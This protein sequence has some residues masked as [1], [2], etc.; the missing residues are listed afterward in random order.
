M[1]KLIENRQSPLSTDLEGWRVVIAQGRLA[2]LRFEP[3]IAAL[4]DL[5]PTSGRIVRVRGQII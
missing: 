3:M 4:Q 5:D 1:K 2:S